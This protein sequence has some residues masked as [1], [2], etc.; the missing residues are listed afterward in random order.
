[1][2]PGSLTSDSLR[3][4]LND[5]LKK[6]E[7]MKSIVMP[8]TVQLNEKAKNQLPGEVKETLA[9]VANTSTKTKF[10]AMDMWNRQRKSRSATAM[11]R[12]WN[13]N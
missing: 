10:T 9:K 2:P 8:K 11:L 13:L 6:G 1:L 7:F 3:R 12:R 4:L 5:R